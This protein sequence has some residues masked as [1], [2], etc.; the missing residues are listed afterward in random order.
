MFSFKKLSI[1]IITISILAGLSVNAVAQNWQDLSLESQWEYIVNNNSDLANSQKRFDDTEKLLKFDILDTGTIDINSSTVFDLNSSNDSPEQPDQEVNVQLSAGLRLNNAIDLSASIDT[2][3]RASVSVNYN[4]FVNA[5]VTPNMQ[6][7]YE[8]SKLDVAQIQLSLK[9]SLQSKYLNVLL[10]DKKWKLSQLNQQLNT[11]SYNATLESFELSESTFEEKSNA[12]N[13]KIQADNAVYQ[14]RNTLLQAQ[15]EYAQL[16]GQQELKNLN[17][18]TFINVVESRQEYIDVAL[19]DH[20]FTSNNL[21]NLKLEQ[22]MLVD[23]RKQIK[24]YEPDMGVSSTYNYDEENPTLSLGVNIKFSMAQF[25]KDDQNEKDTQIAF[26]QSD[27][28]MEQQNLVIQKQMLMRQMNMAQNSFESQSTSLDEQI[29]ITR[30]TQYLFDE[31]E[32]TQ[33][34]LLQQ[35]YSLENSVIS[36]FESVVDL[37]TLQQNVYS[38]LSI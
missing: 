38:A 2:N 9:Q 19:I 6:Y 34:E 15:L 36:K 4:V 37:F 5:Y 8:K 23:Q 17:I 35:Q 16:S 1:N 22:V 11:K 29:I 13:S 18:D 30:E 33:L 27:I 12:R 24:S 10:L 20:I 14:A 7:N 31:G 21:V 25:G 3:E 26:N 28:Q 32:R